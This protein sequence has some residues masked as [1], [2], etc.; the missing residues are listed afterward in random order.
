MSEAAELVR[1]VEKDYT[2][3]R[4]KRCTAKGPLATV[5]DVRV[6][7]EPAHPMGGLG[8]DGC[9]PWDFGDEGRGHELLTVTITA[10][11]FLNSQCRNMVGLMMAVGRGD[12]RMEEAREIVG[13]RGRKG[14]FK[15]VSRR[16]ANASKSPP[17]FLT[18]QTPVSFAARFAR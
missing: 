10:P 4:G 2:W 12:L 8:G 17:A 5:W 6:R 13:N 7:K 16:G 9:F 18:S 14:R 3:A 1:G 11:S 15:K